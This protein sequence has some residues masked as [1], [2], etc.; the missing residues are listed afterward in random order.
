MR[1]SFNVSWTTNSLFTEMVVESVS[2]AT[3]LEPLPD[4]KAPLWSWVVMV[5]AVPT[6]NRR[7]VE[8]LN[9]H[10]PT[11]VYP[12]TLVVPSLRVTLAPST[13]TGEAAMVV[14]TTVIVKVAMVVSV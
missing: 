5:I 3:D 4:Y 2:D 12:I 11:L 6:M 14:S 9:W 13:F 1:E 7:L 10:T 8:D